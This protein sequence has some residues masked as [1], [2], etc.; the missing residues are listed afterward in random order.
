MQV[1]ATAVEWA[2]PGIHG[3]LVRAV[4]PRKAGLPSLKCVLRG[5]IP[6]PVARRIPKVG[7]AGFVTTR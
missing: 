3:M 6:A 1:G 7:Y 5:A 4:Q 2:R